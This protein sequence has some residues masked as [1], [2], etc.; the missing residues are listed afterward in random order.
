MAMMKIEVT[1][2]DIKDG[3]P[4]QCVYCPIAIALKRETGWIW[5]VMYY[6]ADTLLGPF[7]RAIMPPAAQS[8]IEDFDNNE[9]VYPFS[10]DLDVGDLP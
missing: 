4:G 5:S 3:K 7:H 8:W 2:Q 9:S 1:E 10:F 6:S